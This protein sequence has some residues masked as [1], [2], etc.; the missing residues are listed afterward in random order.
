MPRVARAPCCHYPPLA[1]PFPALLVA[2]QGCCPSLA[3]RRPGL[4]PQ[5]CSSRAR[6]TAPALLVA[7]QGAPQTAH[8]VIPVGTSGGTAAGRPCRLGLCYT[9]G[10][11]GFRTIEDCH[12]AVGRAHT[13]AAVAASPDLR[14]AEA[15][16]S[17]RCVKMNGGKSE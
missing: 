13:G 1:T 16:K 12:H 15:I 6:A 3:R 4:L 14:Q 8:P 9:A 11:T 7:G 5:P 17:P 10:P 2:D